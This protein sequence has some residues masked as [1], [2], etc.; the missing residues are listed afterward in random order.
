VDATADGNLAAMAGAPY[1]VGAE[2]YGFPELNMAVTLVFNIEGV[3]WTELYIRNNVTRMLGEI[4]A[5]WGDPNAGALERLIWGYG[6]EAQAYEPADENM[7]LRGPNLAR[8]QNGQILVNALLIFGVNPLDPES[9]AQGLERGKTELPHV[10]EFMQD[11]FKG[12]KNVTLA[13]T[14]ERLYVRE[15]RHFLG[16]YRLTVTDVLENRDHWDRIAHGNYPVD[17]Q[18]K[19]TADRGIVVGQ[20]QIYSIP[21]R[22][23]VPLDVENL[24]IAGRSASYDSLAHGSTRV[25]PV[26]VAAGEAAGAASAISI[27][28]GVNY[29]EMSKDESLIA[30]LQRELVSRGAYLKEYD[31]P[32]DPVMDHWAYPGLKVI[33]AMGMTAG[34]YNNAYGLDEPVSFM[35]GQ[36]TL[37]ELANRVMKKIPG[38]EIPV[39]YFKEGTVDCL[40]L[41]EKIAYLIDQDAPKGQEAWAFLESEGIIDPE[42]SERMGDPMSEA[43]VGA[44][45]VLGARAYEKLTPEF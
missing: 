7:R 25:V 39:I 17:I 12:F 41:A 5:N 30:D 40:Y 20:P 9:V 43:T 3:N 37:N 16:E 27:D 4:N 26:G 28:A 23:L 21:F 32:T 33:R 19:S 34:G 10:I 42:L 18:P 45:Y 31:P 11:H 1:T 38:K 22:C 35:R 24:L 36:N 8:Q 13:D 14:A 2:D 44:L 6:K 15:S 29:R